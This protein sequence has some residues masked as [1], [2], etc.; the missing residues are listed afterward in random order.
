MNEQQKNNFVDIKWLLDEMR[1]MKS[2]FKHLTSSN[3][4]AWIIG[5][6]TYE[7]LVAYWRRKRQI[8]EDRE[9]DSYD[10]IPLVIVTG[11]S[12]ELGMSAAQAKVMR[13]HGKYNKIEVDA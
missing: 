4:A 10:N 8:P 5:I 1:E 12:V 7:R 6:Q 9:A 3:P 2:D 13:S 11:M